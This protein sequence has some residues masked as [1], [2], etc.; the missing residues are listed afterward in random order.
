MQIFNRVV[1]SSD[2]WLDLQQYAIGFLAL[3]ETTEF[4]SPPQFPVFVHI[5]KHDDGQVFTNF[6]TTL[7]ASQLLAANS[8]LY[9]TQ[10]ND[11]FNSFSSRLAK[12]EKFLQEQQSCNNETMALL[13]GLATVLIDNKLTT[14]E[15]LERLKLRLTSNIDQI[16]AERRDKS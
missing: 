14:Q 16:H 5:Q 10:F 15:K 6:T 8:R 4:P 7:E 2:D 3:P 1:L 12:T 11:F 9:I 13:L